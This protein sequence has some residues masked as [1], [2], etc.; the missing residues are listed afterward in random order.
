MDRRASPV[1]NRPRK[2]VPGRCFGGRGEIAVV[3]VGLLA[4][5]PGVG[6]TRQLRV[7]VP[8]VEGK[9]A[10]TARPVAAT[11]WIDSEIARAEASTQFRY[12]AV[13]SVQVFIPYGASL[14]ET[15]RRT[16]KGTFAA[17]QEG[18]SCGQQSSLLVR[19]EWAAPPTVFVTWD[20]GFRE[21]A[22]GHVEFP[23]RIVAFD[24]SGQ[25]LLRRNVLGMYAGPGAPAGAWNVPGEDDFVPIVGEALRDTGEKLAAAFALASTS[26]EP[27]AHK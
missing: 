20:S 2:R 19:V 23:L 3:F 11:L 26:T 5:A 7:S 10:G 24:C 17:V 13:G 15:I 22:R 25:V 16:A 18:E 9:A 21:G 8:A 14:K 27:V 12:A 6:C 4:L 1:A